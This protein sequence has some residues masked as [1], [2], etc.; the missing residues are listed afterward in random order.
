MKTQ[1]RENLSLYSKIAARI[2]DQIRHG[3]LK[4]G[5]RLPSVRKMSELADVSIST[6]QQ[7]YVE[8]E[9]RGIIEARPRSGFFVRHQLVER[10]LKAAS[11]LFRLATS[12]VAVSELVSSCFLAA[13]EPTIV[14]LGSACPSAELF[15]S[16]RLN[17]ILRDMARDLPLHSSEYEF[18]PGMVS[19][20]R[21]IARRSIV[22]G[23]QLSFSEIVTTS[24]GM[25]ALNLCLRAVAQPGDTIAIETPTYFGILQAIESLKM[26]ALP[27]PCDP[28]FGMDLDYLEKAVCETPVK[29]CVV[30]ANFNNPS[31]SLMP[32]GNK[33]RLV[34]ILSLREIPII[35]EDFYGDLAFGQRRPVAVKSFDGDG[36]VLL[37]SSFSKTLAPGFRIGWIAP[38][39]YQAHVERLKFVNTIATPSLPQMVIAEYL[40]NGGYD[41]HI[42]K[43]K[44]E[45]KE[46]ML[47]VR[48]AIQEFFPD[49][50]RVS[51]PAGGFFLWV[52][53]PE[54]V[55]SLRL[56][57]LALEEKIGILPGPIFSPNG[58]FRHCIRL[59]CGNVWS[60]KIED[61]L[62]VLGKICQRESIRR[63]S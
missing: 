7:A 8:L 33:K 54:N 52:E 10:P 49:G 32:E 63:M 12:E 26:R 27:I 35:E 62:A 13:R 50:T 38:G 44:Q 14:Q 37:C 9:S 36:G 51:D 34:E 29:A 41:R 25:E 17:R 1:N 48:C 58:G 23:C 4:G 46:Q 42:R 40:E 45:L 3:S 18:P 5:D 60:P 47:K 30:I 59:N 43:M 53:M 61:A 22:S 56:H 20:R 24:G 15:P 21:Q 31:G 11:G 55:D 39:R 28:K 57:R 2:E 19:L 16:T 6:V